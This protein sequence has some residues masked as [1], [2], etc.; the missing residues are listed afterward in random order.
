MNNTVS[1]IQGTKDSS[2]VDGEEETPRN[3][4]DLALETEPAAA[5]ASSEQ[6]ISEEI[7]DLNPHDV[8]FGRGM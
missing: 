5:A 3:E 1:S 8:L 2:I 7:S 6:A 4:A